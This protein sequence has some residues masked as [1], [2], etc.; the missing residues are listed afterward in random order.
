MTRTTY[1]TTYWINRCTLNRCIQTLKDTDRRN[2][3]WLKE[4]I[5]IESIVIEW[6]DPEWRDTQ[7]MEWLQIKWMD[8]HWMNGYKI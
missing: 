8:A 2:G 6:M 7:C 5:Q 4:E 1:T 3:H